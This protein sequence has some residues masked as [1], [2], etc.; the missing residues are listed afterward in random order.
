M[1]DMVRDRLIEVAQ[2]KK[3]ITYA[4]LVAVCHLQLD[5]RLDHARAE[6]GRILGDISRAE[7]EQGRPLLSVVAVLAETHLPSEGF[8]R[9]AEQLGLGTAKRLRQNLFGE[10]EMAKCFEFWGESRK[11]NAI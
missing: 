1:H 10:R 5:L 4:D 3:T 2:A 6:L 7:Y 8:Y 11:P 9:L